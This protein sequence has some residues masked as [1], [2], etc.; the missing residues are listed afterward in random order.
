MSNNPF[1]EVGYKRPPK[2]TRFKPGQSGNPRSRRKAPCTPFAE[3][4]DK[5]FK[6]NIT[7]RTAGRSKKMTILEAVTRQ[8]V[9]TAALGKPEAL[10]LLALLD[11]YARKVYGGG[12]GV[13]IEIARPCR[14]TMSAV[15]DGNLPEARPRNGT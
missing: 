3:L 7:V 9:D 2:H 15:A 5:A 13:I 6:R 11:A 8:L 10:E 4:I 1:Y 14:R 12:T